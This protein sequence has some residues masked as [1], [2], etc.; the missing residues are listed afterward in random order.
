M[1][2]CISDYPFAHTIRQINQEKCKLL[3]FDTKNIILLSDWKK[4]RVQCNLL[5]ASFESPV[6]Q[7]GCGGHGSYSLF[8]LFCVHRLSCWIVFIYWLICLIS[9]HKL[10]GKHAVQYRACCSY[11]YHNSSVCLR[12]ARIEFLSSVCL[13]WVFAVTVW[14]VC[15]NYFVFGVEWKPS[16]S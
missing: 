10:R 3:S 13:V 4:F 2:A 16:D 11:G 5:G 7:L 15:V 12:C 9:S 8:S 14:D 6:D 1:C